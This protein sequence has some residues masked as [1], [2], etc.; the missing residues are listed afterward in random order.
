ML[1][2][3][4]HELLSYI[5]EYIG[6][7]G[8]S[9]TFEEMK[10]KMSVKSKATI[11]IML[12]E[13]EKKEYIST[14]PLQKR[15]I[16]VREPHN[17]IVCESDRDINFIPVYDGGLDNLAYSYPLAGHFLLDKDKKYFAFK[18]HNFIYPRMMISPNDLLVFENTGK[19]K[20]NDIFLFYNFDKKIHL[21]FF[22]KGDIRKV[23]GILKIKLEKYE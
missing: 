4:Q 6:Q 12:K 8:F 3:K 10:E 1:T 7:N 11:Y 18:N 5:K 19:A 20:E 15:A 14:L 16:L 21:D 17:Y 2:K 22:M 13:L 9:P 23:I